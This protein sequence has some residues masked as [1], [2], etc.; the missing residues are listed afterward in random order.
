MTNGEPWKEC[1][2]KMA[3]D[4][5]RTA[6]PWIQ[7]MIQGDMNRIIDRIIDRIIW[8]KVIIESHSVSGMVW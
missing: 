2:Y 4:L 7:D 8:D 3:A 5:D 1:G 6:E